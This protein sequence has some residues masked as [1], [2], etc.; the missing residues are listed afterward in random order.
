MMHVNELYFY[1]TVERECMIYT[2]QRKVSPKKH[3]ATKKVL[4]E[5]YYK[6]RKNTQMEIYQ[7]ILCKQKQGQS[8]DE[9]I[10]ELRR[11]IKDWICRCKQ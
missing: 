10:T 9:Y 6:P 11:L 2:W 5:D 7:F 1:T 4:V 8:L 3:A